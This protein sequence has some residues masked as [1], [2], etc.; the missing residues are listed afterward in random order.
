MGLLHAAGVRIV[1]GTD[2]PNPFVVPGA[3][4]HLELEALV[5]S[6]LDPW[7]ALAAAT[8][9]A[10]EMN[11]WTDS[12]R[13]GPGARADLLLLAAD[14]LEDIRATRAV[15]GV[16]AAGRWWSGADLERLRAPLVP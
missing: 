4:L 1:A 5:A 6:G 2:T 16:M 13:I 11:G 7:E 15:E 9:R 10:A 12:G 3:A 14:P 8:V